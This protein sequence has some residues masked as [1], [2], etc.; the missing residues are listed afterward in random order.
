MAIGDMIFLSEGLGNRTWTVPNGVTAIK[1]ECFGTTN[2]YEN[3]FS[4][5]A[6]KAPG[7]SYSQTSTLSVT[8]GS[9]VYLNN[10]NIGTSVW[11]NKT[12]NTAPTSTA[13]GCLAVGSPTAAAS[14]VA[15]N[16]GDIK[17]AGGD[18]VVTTSRLLVYGTGGQAG[19]NGA[20]ADAGG[21]YSNTG[22]YNENAGNIFFLGN[23][24]GANG[25]IS[26][27]LGS[28]PYGRS[29]GAFG[30]NGGYWT[31]SA[32]VNPTQDVIGQAQYLITPFGSRPLQTPVNYGPRGGSSG[33]TFAEGE[34]I[35]GIEATG[36]VGFIVITVIAPSQKTIILG[37]DTG[38]NGSFI[39]PSDFGSLVSLRAFG[40]GGIN[41]GGSSASN[42]AGGGGGGY[43]ETLGASVTA[44]MVAGSTLVYYNLPAPAAGSSASSWINIGTNSAP[45][46][47]TSG[48]RAFFGGNTT[49]NIAGAG[50][51][52]ASA[53]GNTKNAGGA[54]GAGFTSSRN[55]GGGGGGAAGP[56]GAGGAG[57]NAWNSNANRG[58]GGGGAV[59]G[60]GAGS[61]APL[62]SSGGAGGSI[63]GG[64]GG[65]PASS[66]TFATEALNGNGGGGGYQARSPSLGSIRSLENGL[67]YV[68]SGDGGKG[69]V[70]GVANSGGAGGGGII[71]TPS[72]FNSLANPSKSPLVILTY[73][74]TVP[75]TSN[76]N[77]FF[78]F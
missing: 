29:G 59:N 62:N 42:G 64:S 20:G 27:G 12:S 22:D 24:G 45:T 44:S 5:T 47:V 41:S 23:G 18:G 58:G 38:T 70:T 50:G 40:G 15:A 63:S 57:G 13:D 2:G 32:I 65:A 11:V 69:G 66:T 73:N 6:A 77:F 19:P 16:V 37:S 53:V 54:G 30:G 75:V 14:Q 76:G 39:L 60:G 72:A 21:L 52:T 9:T 56:S 25:G 28:I 3:L 36:S 26:G 68:I 71:Y 4:E 43:S 1:V 46:S 7:G 55:N 8:A 51:S 61:A 74:P 33:R 17:Y 49:D 78:F 35:W 48:V 67:Y 31:G 34:S 10:S